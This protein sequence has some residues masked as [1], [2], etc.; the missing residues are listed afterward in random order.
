M[1]GGEKMDSTAQVPHSPPPAVSPPRLGLDLQQRP[2]GTA[3]AA[4]V[5]E[6]CLLKTNSFCSGF[7][8]EFHPSHFVEL[9]QRSPV[10]FGSQ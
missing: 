5:T 2:P 10:V 6:G 1:F 7:K 8:A 4:A 9:S 3:V